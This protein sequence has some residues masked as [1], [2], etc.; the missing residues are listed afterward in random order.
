MYKYVRKMIYES[1][2]SA[3]IEINIICQVRERAVEDG[4]NIRGG[5]NIMLKYPEYI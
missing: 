4:Q 2:R 3:N 5:G 1:G